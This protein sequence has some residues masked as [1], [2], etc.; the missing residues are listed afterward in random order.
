MTR[1]IHIIAFVLILLSGSSNSGAVC[2]FSYGIA[3]I[4][5]IKGNANEDRLTE[6]SDPELPLTDAVFC[7]AGSNAHRVCNSRPQRLVSSNFA[8]TAKLTARITFTYYNNHLNPF[9]GRKNGHH[10]A[11]L[12]L[13]VSGDYYIALRHIIR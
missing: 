1:L 8:R 13:T 2:H 5:D 12:F 10:K 4:M 9:Y 6:I 3:D 7:D 11:P